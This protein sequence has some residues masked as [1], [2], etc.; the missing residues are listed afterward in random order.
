LKWRGNSSW[1]K[2][3]MGKNIRGL[4]KAMREEM[5]E[6]E[7]AKWPKANME[8][9]AVLRILE[10]FEKMDERFDQMGGQFAE[11]RKDITD[12]K[13][14]QSRLESSVASVE[15]RLGRVEGKVD[16]IA[17]QTAHFMEFETETRM[18]FEKLDAAG[19]ARRARP[20]R[21]TE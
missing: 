18:R 20:R 3:K 8:D 4:T 21:K 10:K 19:P 11:I 1:L 7:T 12:L 14:G 13:A 5:A 15:R 9:K 2:K 6:N 16:A 17:E